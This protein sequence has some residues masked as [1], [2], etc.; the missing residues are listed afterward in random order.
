M[1][2]EEYVA[3]VIVNIGGVYKEVQLR[4]TEEE[5]KL[6]EKHG[7]ECYSMGAFVNRIPDAALEDYPQT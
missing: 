1:K 7:K 2:K 5:K 3:K 4:L 6:I